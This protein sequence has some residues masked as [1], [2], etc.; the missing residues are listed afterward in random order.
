MPIGA[1]A[2]GDRGWFFRPCMSRRRRCGTPHVSRIPAR[3]MACATAS[4]PDEVGADERARRVSAPRYAMR[5]SLH[6]DPI[7]TPEKGDGA[8]L[9]GVT[10]TGCLSSCHGTEQGAM[11]HRPRP[12]GRESRLQAVECS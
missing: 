12:G 3:S 5:C 4:G 11:V 1:L 10:L 6:V 2:S 9:S 7:V 8:K